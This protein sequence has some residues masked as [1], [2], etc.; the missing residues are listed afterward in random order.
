MEESRAEIEKKLV[1]VQERISMAPRVEQ[2]YDDLERDLT[3]L[4]SKYQ[5]LRDKE[6]QAKIAQNL[7]EG[8]MGERFS[9]IEP[10]TLPEQPT[11][12]KRL[13]LMFIAAIV[14][15]AIGTAVIL[16][17]EQLQPVLWGVNSL[18]AVLGMSPMASIPYIE[19]PGDTEQRRKRRIFFGSVIVVALV[20]I[21]ATVHLL[22]MDLQL[23]LFGHP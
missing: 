1:E 3:N 2:E 23:V 4:R 22:L 8:Q 14:S 7:E 10:P 12:P 18:S 16:V 17:L 6:L 21:L 15:G 20:L 5:E 11:S 9:V 13:R 19:L